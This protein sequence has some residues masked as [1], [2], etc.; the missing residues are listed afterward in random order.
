VQLP[1]SKGP[2]TIMKT[3]NLA[4][5]ALALLLAAGAGAL[6]ACGPSNNAAAEQS[7]KAK[8]SAAEN[9]QAGKLSKA[10]AQKLLATCPIPQGVHQ[11]SLSSW[12]VTLHCAGVPK[13]EWKPAAGCVLKNVENGHLPKDSQGREQYL[14]NAAFPCLQQYHGTATPAPAASK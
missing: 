3:K 14:I 4:V 6:S 1:P 7:A 10:D 12:E 9:S 8:A 2:H 11:L 5:P 13:S